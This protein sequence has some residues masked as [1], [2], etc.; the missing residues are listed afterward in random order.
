[1][2]KN[3]NNNDHKKGIFQRIVY[4]IFMGFSDSVPGYSGG[5]TLSLLNFYEVFINRLKLIF[6]KSSFSDWFKNILWLTPFLIFWF[7]SILCF[8]FLTELIAEKNFDL[9][10]IFL[11]FSFSLF[12]IPLF[13]KEQNIK[14]DF[15]KNKKTKKSNKISASILIFIGFIIFISISIGVY[16]NGG[17]NLKNESSS[18]V[19]VDKNKWGPLMGISFVSGFIM[20]I[21]GISGQLMFYLSNLYKDF[22]WIILQNP[23]SNIS[24]LLIMSIFG[25]IGIILSI[26]MINFLIKK[27]SHLFIPFCIGLVSGSPF[28]ILLGMLGNPIYID[29]LNTL[30]T[31]TN[32]LIAIIFSILIGLLV[33]MFLFI[34][35]RMKNIK[36]LDIF[37]NSIIIIKSKNFNNLIIYQ[38]LKINE[39]NVT[40]NNKNLSNLDNYSK[41]FLDKKNSKIN[42]LKSSEIYILD[43]YN[44]LKNEFIINKV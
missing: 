2:K 25:T 17:I 18:I 23:F 28:A 15:L 38:A 42:N 44:F 10:L 12:C 21:P 7:V 36:N 34:V 3:T 35:F 1:M 40:F 32:L 14:Y 29:E 30:T 33:N 13:I 16:F 9:S 39:I 26:F 8:S 4:G 5:T 24:I 22:S 20:L 27:W 37:S 43:K 31:N 11:F 41:V 19:V 6:K